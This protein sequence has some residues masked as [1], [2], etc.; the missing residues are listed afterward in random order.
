MFL[1]FKTICPNLANY[2]KKLPGRYKQSSTTKDKGYTPL[3]S[4]QDP[5]PF[6]VEAYRT[7]LTNIQFCQ[8]TKPLKTLL[9][10][11][12]GPQ[13]G[14]SSVVANLGIIMAH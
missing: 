3:I 4:N 5:D 9:I 6:L 7:L 10:T 8:P 12:T 1:N 2:V 13:E 14:K 11:S